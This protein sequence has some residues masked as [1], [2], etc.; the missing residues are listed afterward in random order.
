MEEIPAKQENLGTFIIIFSMGILFLI[1]AGAWIDTFQDF[2]RKFIARR[3]R[4]EPIDHL[5]I[6]ITLSIL[7]IFLVRLIFRKH[8]KTYI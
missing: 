2:Y 5:V 8:I 7:F 1:I 4:L 3:P 6:S